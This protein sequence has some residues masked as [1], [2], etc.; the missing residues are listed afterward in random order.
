MRGITLNQSRHKINYIMCKILMVILLSIAVTPLSSQAQNPQ[1]P[2][3]Q[4]PQ[5]QNRPA[6]PPPTLG[7]EQGYME[8]D[9]PDFILKLVKT[10]QTIAALQPK[11]GK[12]FDFTP[13]DRLDRRASDGFYH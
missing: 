12:G 9:T 13:A 7:L 5:G 8:F 4:N 6:A 11:G 1:T 10:S 2:P 3:S